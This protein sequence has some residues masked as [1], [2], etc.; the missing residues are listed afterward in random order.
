MERPFT[1][2][3]LDLLSTALPVPVPV[4]DAAATIPVKP[5]LRR[6]LQDFDPKDPVGEVARVEGEFE[7]LFAACVGE[8]GIHIAPTR[9][10]PFPFPLPRDKP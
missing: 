1:F 7:I 3:L 4:G 9:P 5:A 8:V 10:N 2:V 6:P